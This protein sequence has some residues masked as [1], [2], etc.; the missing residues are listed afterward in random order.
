MR[1]PQEKLPQTKRCG[2]TT[3]FTL[4]EMLAV[5]A[6]I[7]ILGAGIGIALSGNSSS[8][9]ALS[10][11][12]RMVAS[13]FQAAR[14]N[15]IMKGQETAVIIYQDGDFSSASIDQ[16]KAL[17]FIGIVTREGVGSPWKPLNRGSYLPKGIYFVPPKVFFDGGESSYNSASPLSIAFPI[18]TGA[19]DN[20]YAYTFDKYGNLSGP[21]T[22][23]LF[24]PSSVV[25][26]GQSLNLD[27]NAPLNQMA[28]IA[29]RKTGGVLMIDSLDNAV[30]S[31]LRS[32]VNDMQ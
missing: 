5:I 1:L 14:T 4:V 17:R 18:T 21:S 2:E 23:L 9:A 3:A 27:R 31:A 6:I 20:W 26:T 15:A 29:I 32:G 30:Y 8:T 12:Q 24:A 13:M 10:N 22:Y 28:G 16:E 25:V 19:A 7:G 11:A